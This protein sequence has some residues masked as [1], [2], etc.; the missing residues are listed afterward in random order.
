MRYGL[1]IISLKN[2][3]DDKMRSRGIILYSVIIVFLLLTLPSICAI[4]LNTITS[5]KKSFSDEIPE[6][7]TEQI[8]EGNYSRINNSAL[9]VVVVSLLLDFIAYRLIIENYTEL[10][11]FILLINLI[12]IRR[13]VA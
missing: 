10:A 3:R 4:R 1:F 9:L 13:Y 8:D 7:I 2:L 5:F 11:L 6:M 12:I